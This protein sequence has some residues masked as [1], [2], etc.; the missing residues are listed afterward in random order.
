MC[1]LP[2]LEMHSRARNDYIIARGHPPPTAP[3]LPDLPPE[4][5]ILILSD[6]DCVSTIACQLT[7]SLTDDLIPRRSRVSTSSSLRTIAWHATC[8]FV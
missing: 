7:F 5:L 1:K 8:R 4:L 3:H 6:W 2:V